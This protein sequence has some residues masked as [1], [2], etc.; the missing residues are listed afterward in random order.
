MNALVQSLRTKHFRHLKFA[1][2]ELDRRDLA[3]LFDILRDLEIALYDKKVIPAAHWRHL[4]IKL[5]RHLL[6]GESAL[7][8]LDIDALFEAVE[9]MNEQLVQN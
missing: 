5:D 1:E 6:H 7:V 2:P 9:V 8:S 3:Q 4:S